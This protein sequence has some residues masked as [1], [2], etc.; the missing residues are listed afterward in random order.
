MPPRTQLL[1]ISLLT[2]IGLAAPLHIEQARIEFERPQ[3][4]IHQ[5]LISI[6]GKTSV[7]CPAQDARTAVIFVAG[8]SNVAN[9]GLQRQVTKYGD[10]VLAWFDGNCTIAQSPLLGVTGID[11][12]S[13]TLL[14]DRLIESGAYDRIILAPVAVGGSL[15]RDWSSGRLNGLLMATLEQTIARWRITHMVWH[16]GESDAKRT[17]PAAWSEDLRSIVAQARGLGMDAPVLV[18]VVTRC[19]G[20]FPDWTPDNRLARAQRALPDPAAGIFAGPDVDRAVRKIDRYEWGC[21]YRGSGQARFA[22]ALAERIL[23]LAA[24]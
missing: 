5:R 8:Q 20:H 4:D 3:V 11:G 15:A 23:S 7:A 16:Q 1:S 24:Q 17:D 22:Q 9:S 12:E 13:L 10:K 6:E 18:S 19:T 14:G 21:H 2:A